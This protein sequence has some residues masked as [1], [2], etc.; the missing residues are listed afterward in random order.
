[1]CSYIFLD[2]E[3]IA[4]VRLQN[5]SYLSC[6]ITISNKPFPNKSKKEGQR[7]KRSFLKLQANAVRSIQP[8]KLQIPNYELIAKFY[9]KHSP[10]QA[11]SSILQPCDFR[12]QTR[13][14]QQALKPTAQLHQLHSKPY[15]AFIRASACAGSW[16]G[17]KT[18]CRACTQHQVIHSGCA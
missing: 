10:A 2:I 3:R 7:G 4:V 16:C 11:N 9:T 12:N 8:L 5:Q 15:N 1:M 17:Q 14:Q 6:F 18:A 13:R